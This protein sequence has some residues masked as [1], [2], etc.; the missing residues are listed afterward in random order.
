MR[1][2]IGL[3]L[4]L[5]LVAIITCS[6]YLGVLRHKRKLGLILP[7]DTM[8]VEVLEA[9]PN[10]PISGT[11]VVRGDGTIDL[12]IYGS[13]P[14]SSCTLSEFKTRLVVHL[15][16]TLSDEILG[17]VIDG[18]AIEPSQCDRIY[19]DWESYPRWLG[20]PCLNHELGHY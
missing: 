16:Q 11:R 4:W 9:L 20:D 12:G 19:V 17:L 1:L 18:H 15:R 14:V 5:I 2:K 8:Q 3:K 7:G 6:T 13:L 10:H